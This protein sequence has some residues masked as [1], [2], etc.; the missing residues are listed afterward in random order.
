MVEIEAQER[1]LSGEQSLTVPH[2]PTMFRGRGEYSVDDKGRLTLPA[3]MRKALGDVGNLVVLDGRAVIWAELTYRNAVDEL[4]RKV[5][6]GDLNQAHVRAFLANTHLVSADTQGRIV[7][8]HA[9]RIEA[10]L[11]REVVVLG[12]GPRIEILPAG[13]GLD[14]ALGIDSE[15]VDAL[16]RANF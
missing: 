1:E 10:G 7:V 15:I 2:L 3:Q 16:D 12:S 8:P 9:V 4:N 13:D 14:L 6:T 5:A 11:D